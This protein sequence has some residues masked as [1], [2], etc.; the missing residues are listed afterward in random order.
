MTISRFF[1]LN[2]AGPSLQHQECES[3][4]IFVD[5]PSNTSRKIDIFM[6]SHSRNDKVKAV[7]QRSDVDGF[8]SM[9]EC[10]VTENRIV[11]LLERLDKG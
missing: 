7:S 6:K 11:F 9:L 10:N 1:F 4:N 2:I 5:L 3:R 8:F